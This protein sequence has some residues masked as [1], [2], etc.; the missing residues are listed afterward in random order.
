MAVMGTALL[1]RRDVSK[2]WKN[3]QNDEIVTVCEVLWYPACKRFPVLCGWQYCAHNP[4]ERLVLGQC[5]VNASVFSNKILYTTHIVIRS[6]RVCTS[7][8]LHV[9]DIFPAA[10]ERISP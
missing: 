1:D 3:V 2:A 7:R 10:I 9:D 5:Q 8:S 4:A 6:V